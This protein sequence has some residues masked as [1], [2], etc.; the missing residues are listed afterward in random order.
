MR[1]SFLLRAV[2]PPC[3]STAANVHGRVAMGV[4][5]VRAHDSSSLRR[6]RRDRGTAVLAR[7]RRPSIRSAVRLQL[8]MEAA[9]VLL[10]LLV[11]L[12]V[13]V[14]GTVGDA[15]CANLVSTERQV[16]DDL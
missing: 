7:V 12:V 10:R 3:V 5:P 14:E 6:A 8:R 16:L 13:V 1:C 2:S 4:P 15:N 11:V 9:Q